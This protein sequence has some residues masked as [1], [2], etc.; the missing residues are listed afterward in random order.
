MTI[1]RSKFDDLTADLVVRCIGPVKQAMADAKLTANDIDE[2]LLVGG[3]TRM[4]A[5]QAL[6][7]RLT[8]GKDPT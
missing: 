2:V 8:G 1:M 4:P 3:A 5:V 6:V 7:R